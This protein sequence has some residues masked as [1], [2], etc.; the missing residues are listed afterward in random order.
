MRNSFVMTDKQTH[1]QTS[2][3][4]INGNPRCF[5]LWG[6]HL[7][8][9]T[10]KHTNKIVFQKR[11]KLKEIPLRYWKKQQVGHSP[12]STFRAPNVTTIFGI[13]SLILIKYKCIKKSL[14]EK[15]FALFFQV[16]KS[17]VTPIYEARWDMP[18][19]P[20]T[21]RFVI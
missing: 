1:T 19:F 18:E 8:W 12:L 4:F 3:N 21:T 7:W 13:K 5:H 16:A 10:N 2:K 6:I 15:G 20:H 9:P 17:Q 11:D 14:L